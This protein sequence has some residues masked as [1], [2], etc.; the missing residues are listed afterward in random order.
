MIG[1]AIFVLSLSVFLTIYVYLGYPVI[2]TLLAKLFPKR[3]S[4]D[5]SYEPKVTLVISCYNEVDVIEEKIKNTLEVDYP[6]DKFEIIF[7]SDGSDDGTD[8]AVKARHESNIKLVRQEGRLGKTSALNMTV[9]VSEGDIIVF[10]DANAMYDKMAVRKL[11]RHFADEN[12]GYVVGAALYTDGGESS[13]AQSEDSYWKYEIFLKEMES[14]L[15]SVV[16]GDGAIYA[17]RKPLFETLDREDI[18]DFV[19]P[20]QIIAKQYRGIFDKEAICLEE[21]A[22]EF[23]KEGRRKQR[24][25]NRSFRGLMKVRQVMNPFAYGFF[26]FAVISHKLM[27][28]LVPVYLIGILVGSGVL[29]HYD[30]AWAEN[31]LLLGIIFFALANIG[32]RKSNEEQIS[33]LYFYPYYFLLVNLQSLLGIRRALKGDIQ[34]TWSTSRDSSGSQQDPAIERFFKWGTWL[35]IYLSY[36]AVF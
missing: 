29:A 13:A 22:G 25:V 4:I 8:E 6:S 15:H 35:A 28:W 12:V 27:R 34:I 19:N 26:S 7:V 30:L 18:N 33:P 1:L 16:G 21:T 31:I 10:S 24:I 2:L 17:I 9:P 11:V 23:D 36:H 32:W 3:H 14:N 20:L 5:D